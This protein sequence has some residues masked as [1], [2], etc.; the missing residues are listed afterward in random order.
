MRSTADKDDKNS[1]ATLANILTLSRF[2]LSLALLFAPVFSVFFYIVYT[3]CGLT[4]MADG[5]AA[6]MTDTVSER[7]AKLDSVADLVFVAVCLVKILPA[8]SISIWLWICIG[9]IAAVKLIN[10]ISGFIC[11][12]KPI[13]LHTKANKL[14]GLLL[15]LLPFA[16][17]F[18]DPAAA[19]IPV[20]AVAL[21]AAVQE[22]HYIRRGRC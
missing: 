10:L 2:P 1:I 22:G 21:F 14:T 5:V 8:L 15:F 4:D 6:R 3:V 18:A 16:L 19:A 9:I 13:F 12:G 17:I 20:C 11:C 7:G